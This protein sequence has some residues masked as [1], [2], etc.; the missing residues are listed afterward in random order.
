[1][2][3]LSG[4][5]GVGKDAAIKLMQQQCFPMHYAVT[6]TTRP[7]RPNE[8]AGKDYIFL[9][10]PQ[11]DAMLAAEGF[12]EH[13]DVYGKCYG[14][15]R[16]Q[17]LEP[18]ARGEDVLLKIDVQGADTV[19][20]KLPKA[21]RIFLAPS[22]F[23]ELRQRLVDRMTDSGEAL[24]RRLL[25]AESEMAHAGEFDYVVYNRADQLEAAVA[26]IQ[27]IV[28][29]EKAEVSRLSSHVAP[30]TAAPKPET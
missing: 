29:K 23:Q 6:A 26:E 7:I 12:L 5:S 13:A 15:P 11:F 18:L 30:E 8:V 14:T 22:N 3:I 2:F 10:Q 1:L 21:I 19:K 24:Q 25:E 9:S 20:E 27:D 17:V 16:D 28:R 4:P